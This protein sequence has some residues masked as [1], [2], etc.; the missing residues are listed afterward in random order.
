MLTR[1]AAKKLEQRLLLLA[2]LTVISCTAVPQPE[3]LKLSNGVSMTITEGC[4]MVLTRENLNPEDSNRFAIDPESA[5]ASVIWRG[6][7]SPLSQIIVMEAGSYDPPIALSCTA[8]SRHSFIRVDGVPQSAVS[9]RPVENWREV[10]GDE[11]LA[12][13]EKNVRDCERTGPRWTKFWTKL[14]ITRGEDDQ[15][16]VAEGWGGCNYHVNQ[17]SQ[18]MFLDVPGH[19]FIVS[20]IVDDLFVK[21]LM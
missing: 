10:A 21:E 20:K 4:P 16:I 14:T 13:Y 9:I 11:A 19:R 5:P 17:M 7:V 8:E 12:G 3:V 1:S 2:G 15:Q 18:A 6:E